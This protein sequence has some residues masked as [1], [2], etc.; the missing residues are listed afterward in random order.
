M[1]VGL[2]RRATPDVPLSIGL[3]YD[4]MINDNFGEFATSPYLSQLRL[5][6]G[7]IV[8]QTDELGVW[9]TQH[10]PGKDRTILGAED[11]WR[12][13][14]QYNTFWRHYFRKSS[15]EVTNWLGFPNQHRLNGDGS[16]GQLILGSSGMH[17]LRRACDCSRSPPT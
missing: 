4:G 14:S 8:S 12:A 6:A 10:G 9:V 15:A 16:L 17:R 11:S 3:V 2:F 13:I 1:T 5:K 7:F